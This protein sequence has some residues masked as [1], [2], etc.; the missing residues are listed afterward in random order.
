[1]TRWRR[2][3]ARSLPQEA[4]GGRARVHPVLAHSLRFL[5]ACRRTSVLRC[6]RR[7]HG[8]ARRAGSQ[9]HTHRTSARQWRAPKQWAEAATATQGSRTPLRRARAARPGLQSHDRAGVQQLR[10]LP[11]AAARD[12]PQEATPHTSTSAAQPA[13]GPGQP[14]PWHGRKRHTMT[15]CQPPSA[16]CLRRPTRGY[17]TP[18]VGVVRGSFQQRAG[19]AGRPA[20]GSA[21]PARCCTQRCRRAPAKCTFSRYS[22]VPICPPLAL[23]PATRTS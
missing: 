20:G 13:T 15:R 21:P 22:H 10:H 9:P 12:A 17:H 5:N 18:M 16:P 1:M 3:R 7:P 8:S 4:G 14:R 23:H 19:P 6:P 2:S 11:P